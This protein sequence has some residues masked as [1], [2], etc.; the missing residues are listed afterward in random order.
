MK[1]NTG[2]VGPF[3]SAATPFS[4]KAPDATAPKGERPMNNSYKFVAHFLT[5]ALAI[6][7]YAPASRVQGQDLTGTVEL[8]FLGIR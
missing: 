4:L 1:N 3:L 5:A 8:T 2:T 6:L 7:S